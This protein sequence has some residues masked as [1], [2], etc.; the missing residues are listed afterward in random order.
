MYSTV[1]VIILLLWNTDT[2]SIHI[3]VYDIVHRTFINRDDEALDVVV[4]CRNRCYWLLCR[5][6]KYVSKIFT[7]INFIFHTSTY[8]ILKLVNK[9][10]CCCMINKGLLAQ[11]LLTQMFKRHSQ[12]PWI[13]GL[14]RLVDTHRV[15][16]S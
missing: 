10:F 4:S 3:K 11:L 15:E 9:C 2:T 13:T 12:V 16:I 1:I 6:M 8:M 7:Q 5:R 14:V